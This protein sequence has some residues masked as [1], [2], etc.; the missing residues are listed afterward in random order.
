MQTT[1]TVFPQNLAT[2]GFY[3]KALVS[4]AR[5]FA[6]FIHVF[7]PGHVSLSDFKQRPEDRATLYSFKTHNLKTSISSVVNIRVFVRAI[8]KH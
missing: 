2:A 1:Y 4:V 3:F 7:S 6:I 5:Y 8:H